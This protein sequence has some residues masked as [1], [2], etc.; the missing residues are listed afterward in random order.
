M[1][2]VVDTTVLVSVFSDKDKFH[3]DGIRLYSDILDRKIEPI[4]PTLAFPE[5]C[6]VI[7]RILGEH[8]AIMVED[9]L[10]LLVDNEV[11]KAEELTIKRMKSSVESA[12]RYSVRGG[13]AVFISLTEE[14]DAKL[15]TFDEE[16]K[17]KI[18]G[19]V[20]LFKI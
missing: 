1:R 3:K 15:A 8:I 14:F 16:L 13:D 18:K 4:I 2:V 7:R 11:L 9:Q 5:T 10:N 17:K 12:I 19:R 6:G 20:K